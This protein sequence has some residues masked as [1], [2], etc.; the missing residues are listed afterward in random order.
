[1]LLKQVLVELVCLALID[2]PERTELEVFFPRE[3]IPETFEVDAEEIFIACVIAVAW[4]GMNFRCGAGAFI[5]VS[6][7]AS[8]FD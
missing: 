6:F 4:S 7:V 2:G 1:M 3:E 5:V 8:G